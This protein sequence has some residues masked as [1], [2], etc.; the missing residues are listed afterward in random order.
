MT[1]FADHAG[2]TVVQIVKPAAMGP[3]VRSRG[4]R[5]TQR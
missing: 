3:L 2:E 1:V 4:R 5:K